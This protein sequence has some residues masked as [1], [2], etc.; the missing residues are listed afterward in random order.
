MREIYHLVIAG[1]ILSAV[2]LSASMMIGGFGKTYSYSNRT[3]DVTF[4]NV[5]QTM[6]DKLNDTQGT[7]AGGKLVEGTSGIA[8]AINTG[9]SAIS[10]TGT[11]ITYIPTIYMSL[12]TSALE[13]LGL[14][15]ASAWLSVIIN[16]ILMAVVVFALFRAIF[17]VD[18]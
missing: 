4:L 3:A 17:K 2:A 9:W 12:T 11:L 16:G 10:S 7:L 1:F 15:E 6:M 18:L 5:S 14:G 13:M 8:I